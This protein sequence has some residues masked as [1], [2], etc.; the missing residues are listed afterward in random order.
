VPVVKFCKFCGKQLKTAQQL[1]MKSGCCNNLCRK[2]LTKEE[3]EESARIEEL[4]RYATKKH[5]KKCRVCG[6]PCFPN[7][8][9]CPTHVPRISD[10]FDYGV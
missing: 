4:L 6:K 2:S 3:N 5:D 10:P 1:K 8:F 9:Y 7:Y